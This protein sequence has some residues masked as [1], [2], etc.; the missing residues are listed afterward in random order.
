M[1]LTGEENSIEIDDIFNIWDGLKKE[2]ELKGI[3]NSTTTEKHHSVKCNCDEPDIH[4]DYTN[5]VM[6]C[7]SCGQ[8][9]ENIVDTSP[10]WNNYND[11]SNGMSTDKSRCGM[12]TSTLLSEGSQF[13]TIIQSTHKFHPQYRNLYRWQASIGLH[14]RDRSLLLNYEKIQSFCN[15]MDINNRICEDAKHIYKI[16]SQ[17]KLSRG[18]IKDGILLSCILFA[19]N[20][21]KSPR[22]VNELCSVCDI[23]TKCIHKTNKIITNILW[24]IPNYKKLMFLYKNPNQFVTRFCSNLG[25]DNYIMMKLVRLCDYLTEKHNAFVSSREASYVVAGII[26]HAIQKLDLKIHKT[27]L[28]FRCNLSI[29]TLNKIYVDI[30]NIKDFME[31]QKTVLS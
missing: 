1:S 28:C 12:P 6:V 18:K 7:L 27:V 25:I 29:V 4:C 14:H 24:E 3:N 23:T 20:E 13:G 2:E 22:N 15:K 17:K 16:I 19:C 30:T 5:A 9:Q 31:Y 10:E 21:N 8:V 26:W 11:D